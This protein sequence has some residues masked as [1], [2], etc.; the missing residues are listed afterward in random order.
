MKFSMGLMMVSVMLLAQSAVATPI[1]YDFYQHG[2]S[3]QGVVS[4]F[5]S[6]SDLDNDGVLSSLNGEVTGFQLTFSRHNTALFSLDLDD[7]IGLVYG[8]DGL[9]G[10]SQGEGILAF[11]WNSLFAA[12]PAVLGQTCGQGSLCALA[13]GPYALGI[14][15]QPLQVAVRVPEPGTVVLLLLGVLGLIWVRRRNME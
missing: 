10:D 12:G 9:L 4:G 2:Y 5:F 7:L 15:N 13:I 11:N 3:H 6:G 8:L 1:T 14:T